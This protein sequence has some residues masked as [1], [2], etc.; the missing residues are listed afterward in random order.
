MNGDDFD[1]SDIYGN[2]ILVDHWATTC[3]SCIEAMP[4][5]HEFYLRF[6]SEGF[7]VASVCYDCGEN[8]D[9]ASRLEKEMGL[10]WPMIVAD[11]QWERVSSQYGYSGVPQ[12]MLLNRD[13]TLYAGTAEINEGN[14]LENLVIRMLAAEA[15]EQEAA[16]VH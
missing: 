3:A 10:S 2:I 12:Y 1:I 16:T 7:E 4:K 15:A 9:R 13:G 5:I 6:K 14:N 8:Q 11:D